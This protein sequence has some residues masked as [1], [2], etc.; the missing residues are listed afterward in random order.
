MKKLILAMT[1]LILMAVSCHKEALIPNCE[2]DNA[3]HIGTFYSDEFRDTPCSLQNV[4]TDDKV[5]NHVI[6]TQGDYEKYI[7]CGI[8]R[9]AVDFEKYYILAG[10]YRHNYGAKLYTQQVLICNN[11]IIYEVR[12]EGQDSNTFM[13]VFYATVIERKYVNMSIEFDVKF[14][15]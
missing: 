1:S 10:R 9:P 3:Y 8:Q 11:K 14:I 12:L 13:D 5:V 2:G 4:S 7:A 15:N 6:K